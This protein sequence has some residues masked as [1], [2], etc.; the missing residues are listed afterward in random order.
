MTQWLNQHSGSIQALCQRYDVRCLELFGSAAR[1]DFDP[2]RSDVDFV[3]V[4]HDRGWHGSFK[5][6]MGL[7][8]GLEDLLGRPVDLI[9]PDGI[10]NPHFVTQI[11]S[12]RRP[13]YAA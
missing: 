2:C 1:D 9:E 3:V 7:K 5:R 8:L 13:I 6:Y 11:A 10:T 4:F 12:D